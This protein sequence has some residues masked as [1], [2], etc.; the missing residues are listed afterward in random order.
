MNQLIPEDV[1]AVLTKGVVMPALP[2]ALNSKR[3]LDE[4]RQGL[5]RGT[6]TLAR[7]ER[8]SPGQKAEIDRVYASYP[9]L[10]DDAFVMENLDRWLS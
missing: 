2:L 7:H 8:L 1:R 10:N 5:F 6:W 9:E 3:K 4:R